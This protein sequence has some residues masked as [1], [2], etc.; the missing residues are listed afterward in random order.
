M[1]TDLPPSYLRLVE[2]LGGARISL[3]LRV[4]A[5]HNV[6]DLLA[7]APKTAEQ[8]SATTGLP[9]ANLGRLLR[10]LA[11]L[12][13]FE[14][15]SDGRYS[16]TEVSNYMRSDASPSLRAMILILNDGAML[17]S[18]QQLPSVMESGAPAFA[19]VN[20]MPFFQYIASDPQR[21]ELM[22]KF[23]AGI[24]GPE[25]A[26]IAE[27]FPFS[28]F[29]SI[30][31]VGGAQGH[32]LA[33]IL[34]RHP[35]IRGALFDLPRT[36]DVAREYL[37]GKGFVNC[38]VIAG[39]FI[40]AVPRGFDAYFVKSVLH[41]WDDETCVQILRNCRDAM[42]AEG[43]VLVAEIVVEPGKP[44]GHP[45]RLIDLEMMVN[46]GGKERTKDEFSRLLDGAGLKLTQVV[47]IENSFFS[48]VE[49]SRL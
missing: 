25:G 2:L 38:E 9:A 35:D 20:G 44:V 3:A 1:P 10:G 21:S 14:E 28:R 6:A 32:V 47:P 39:D 24:Y 46:L 41:D 43:R 23:M 11:G 33:D 30:V 26:R 7:D 45:Y 40:E 19:A 17:K 5:E 34:Q 4:A 22:S 16:N 18:W 29:R 13:V 37:S 27:G 48:V 31:D 12:G 49:A 15:S 8:L 42:P 36:A